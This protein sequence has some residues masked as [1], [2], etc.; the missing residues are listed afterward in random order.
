M[1]LLLVPVLP[2]LAGLA[3]LALPRFGAW[4]LPLAL[5][6]DLALLAILPGAAVGVEWL[7]AGPFALRLGL[8]ATPLP[9]GAALVVC[10]VA[11][12]VSV[13]AV[14]Y[15]RGA[16]GGRRL[17]AGLGG[18][19]A[20]MLVVVLAADMITLFA[21]WE[22]MGVASFA[23]IAH[24]WSSA[25]AKAAAVRAFVMTRAGDAGLLLAWLIPL[26][27]LGTVE[28]DAVN[29]AGLPPAA[30]TAMAALLLWGAL[31]KSAQLPFSAWLPEAM[32][33][34]TPVSALLHSATMVAA[35][36]YLLL[37][38]YP[39]LSAVPVALDMVLLAGAATALLAALIATAQTNIKRIGAWSTASQIGETMMATGLGGPLAAAFHLTTHAVFK[40]T[41]FLASGAVQ[42][43][44][45]GIEIP[46][47]GGLGRRMPWTAAAY[48]AAA[49]G[50]AAVPPLAGFWSAEAIMA[51]AAARGPLAATVLV[52]LAAL[53]GIYIGR[54]AGATFLG[55]PAPGLRHARDP[56][57]TMLWPMLIMAAAVAVAGWLLHGRLAPLLPFA[58]AAPAPWFWRLAVAG[59]ALAGFGHG[60]W[61]GARFAAAPAAGRFPRA[62]EGG[63]ALV[64]AAA[65]AAAWRLAAFCD[66]VERRLD[67]ATRAAAARLMPGAAR[68]TVAVE[69]RLEGAARALATRLMP[70]AARE[71]VAVEH[72]LDVAAARLAG[73]GAWR[74]AL[75]AERS[76]RLG[77]GRG[78]DG[79]A[80]GIG[81]GGTA[82]A[83]LQSGKVFLY[84]LALF[85]WTLILAA[86]AALTFWT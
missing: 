44:M 9:W 74:L 59:A 18:F 36:S 64:P 30:A 72:L 50:V 48:F 3:A 47:L 67:G 34:P 51:H 29:A 77:F 82:A 38:L 54:A 4:L 46:R 5:A 53:A 52:L 11:L 85:A 31:G 69:R 28:I 37:R 66:A 12:M 26:T 7:R 58:A 10:A 79:L 65:T 23:L 16:P 60:L 21:G 49:L 80:L 70:G 78:G 43:A 42:K 76:E 39:A 86:A 45:G 57:P 40:A 75:R 1:T 81:V 63:V 32:V 68:G 33:A 8:E 25:E 19:V 56:R 6:A 22:L 61:R 24:S 20:A 13:H 2:V 27:L 84:T 14:G 35:G 71:T 62:L 55:P 15:M 83:R 17:T 41:L 73:G